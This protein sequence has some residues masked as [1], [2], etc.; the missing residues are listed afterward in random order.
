MRR[1]APW[2]GRGGRKA[3]ST[4][5]PRT[6]TRWVRSSGAWQPRRCWDAAI[7]RQPLHLADSFP[8][9]THMATDPYEALGVSRTASQDEIRKAFRKLAKKNHPDLNPGDK[10]AGER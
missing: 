1:R 3:C 4:P 6:A 2:W 10:A 8:R 5:S 9:Y 7:R